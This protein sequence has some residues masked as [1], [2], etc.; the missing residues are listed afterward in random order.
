ML[1]LFLFYLLY[2]YLYCYYKIWLLVSNYSLVQLKT[3]TLTTCGCI[4]KYYVFPHDVISLI[5][6]VKLTTLKTFIFTILAL[7]RKN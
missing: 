2:A 5:D 1:F 7:I 4:N 6:V 3:P